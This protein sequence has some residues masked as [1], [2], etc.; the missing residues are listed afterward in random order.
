M[1][2]YQ[3]MWEDIFRSYSLNMW[4]KMEK[5]IALF[6]AGVKTSRTLRKKEFLPWGSINIYIESREDVDT[7]N[8][9]DFTKLVT[10]S[11][12]IIG[13]MKPWYAMDEFMRT[14]LKKSWIKDMNPYTYIPESAD[15]VEAKRNLE[16]LNNNVEI[17]E[18]L[19]NQDLHTLRQIYSQALPTDAKRKILER[20]DQLIMDTIHLEQQEG[21]QTDQ[22]SS[23]M[24]M[25]SVLSQQNNNPT[26]W[27]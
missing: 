20:I 26:L 25:N 7:Q 10:V 18:P 15:E 19:P 8:E 2:S 5:H 1:D 14:V 4:E 16:L 6:D 24:A 3:Q 17:S 9:K 27:S 13:N 23:S 12:L 21:W 11:N 22:A